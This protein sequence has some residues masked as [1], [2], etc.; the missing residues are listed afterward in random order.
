[1]MGVIFL[2]HLNI[3]TLQLLTITPYSGYTF[4][5]SGED[6]YEGGTRNSNLASYSS[7]MYFYIYNTTS[8]SDPDERVHSYSCY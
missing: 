7:D 4:T 5:V 3:V 6:S 2:V 8:L 1:M